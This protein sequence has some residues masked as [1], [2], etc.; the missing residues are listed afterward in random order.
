MD[1]F[2][3]GDPLKP[4]MLSLEQKQTLNMCSGT[5][6]SILFV[7]LLNLAELLRGGKAAA[8]CGPYIPLP[9]PLLSFDQLTFPLNR[10]KL[11]SKGKCRA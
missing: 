3:A 2:C 1:L 7:V 6:A 11:L 10:R 9:W 5:S 8:G 4:A